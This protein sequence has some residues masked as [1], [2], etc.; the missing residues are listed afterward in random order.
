MRLRSMRPMQESSVPGRPSRRSARTRRGTAMAHKVLRRQ[1]RQARRGSMLI[2]A[3]GVLTLIS[4][5]AVTFVTLMRLEKNAATNFVDGIK[6][7]MVAEAGLERMVADM[8]RLVI[9]P[10]FTA[11]GQLKPFV[12]GW[13]NQRAPIGKTIDVARPV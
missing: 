1:Q 9:E 3:L 10:P 7:K 5:L 2:V 13:D 4:V 12:F 8:R 11:G 6:A